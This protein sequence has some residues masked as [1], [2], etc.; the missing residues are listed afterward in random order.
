MCAVGIS[1]AGCERPA[2]PIE[3]QGVQVSHVT[4][5]FIPDQ[6]WEVTCRV[7]NREDVPKRVRLNVGMYF[8][9]YVDQPPQE[10][11]NDITIDLQPHESLT[12]ST[13]VI[14]RREWIG[15]GFRRKMARRNPRVEILSVMPIES[16]GA[17][18]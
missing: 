11:G 3:R 2:A 8:L 18:R 10:V 4:E 17:I 12:V 13:Q 15:V 5:R 1:L 16:P 6:R 9:P 14:G 7:M